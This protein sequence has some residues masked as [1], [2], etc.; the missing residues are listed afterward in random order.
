MDSRCPK[1]WKTIFES[2]DEESNADTYTEARRR[3]RKINRVSKSTLPI[4]KVTDADCPGVVVETPPRVSTLK[5][6]FE[7]VKDAVKKFSPSPRRFSTRKY[8]VNSGACK[9][10]KNIF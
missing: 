2:E 8:S 9:S 3:L 7:Q 1:K 5:R 4:V 6:K 10:Q